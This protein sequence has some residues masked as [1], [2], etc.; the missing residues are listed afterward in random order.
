MLAATIEAVTRIVELI[1]HE[2]RIWCRKNA[3][4]FY[5][6][7]LILLLFAIFNTHW[8]RTFAFGMMNYQ[9]GKAPNSDL[10]VSLELS[11]DLQNLY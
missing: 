7:H 11:K 2:E 3:S 1:L 6:N 8:F 4:I 10:S 5:D 9:L